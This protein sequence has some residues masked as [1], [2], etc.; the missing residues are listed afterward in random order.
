MN[1]ESVLNILERSTTRMFTESGESIKAVSPNISEHPDSLICV[2]SFN[3]DASG[4]VIVYWNESDALK[5]ASD[6]NKFFCGIDEPFTSINGDVVE[7]IA[8][9]TNEIAGA[10]LTSLS[11]E[12][13][14]IKIVTPI[15]YYGGQVA[16]PSYNSK[17]QLVKYNLGEFQMYLG[18]YLESDTG[19]KH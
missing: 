2:I 10:F 14:T 6:K 16:Y 18:L 1:T 11:E 12:D 15:I 19:L 7:I 9:F 3:G 17:L 4:Q 8:E 13:V 5:F